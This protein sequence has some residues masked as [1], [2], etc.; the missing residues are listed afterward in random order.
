ME[1]LKTVASGRLAGCAGSPVGE[2]V[3]SHRPPPS[4][5]YNPNIL[6]SR[7]NMVGCISILDVD[8]YMNLIRAGRRS[9]AKNL[10]CIVIR[11]GTEV[12]LIDEVADKFKQ[13]IWEF[14]G[15]QLPLW[16]IGLYFLDAR[17]LAILAECNRDSER[18]CRE[19]VSA[20]FKL[21]R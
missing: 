15:N 5:T 11:A 14:N 10:D 16:V 2:Y 1:A 4:R 18:G 21:V 6:S 9:I 19:R 13:V 12:V 8:K 17:D 20:D 7:D 3:A